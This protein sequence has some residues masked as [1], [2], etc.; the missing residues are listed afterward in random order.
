M[1][2]RRFPLPRLILLTLGILTA[3]NFPGAQTPTP[4]AAF[5]P[6]PA[7]DAP[8]GSH[9]NP[10]VL[11]LPPA[12]EREISESGREA[13]AQLSSLTG[14]VIIPYAP[15]SY[16][17]LVEALGEGRVH[18]AW[19]P[20]LPYLLAH[21]NGHADAALA[22]TVHEVDLYAA[23]FLVN[24]QQVEGGPFKVHFDPMTGRNLAQA[25]AA[26]AQFEGRKPCWTDSYSPYSYV[27]P[28][29]ILAENGI[30]TKPGAFMQGDEAVIRSL[31]RDPKGE[32]CQFGVTL[33]D[34]R[35][36][37]AAEYADV[38]EQ[39]VVVWVTDAIVPLNGFAYAPSLSSELRVS[40]SAAFLAILGNEAGAA[41]LRDAFPLTV[42]PG[43]CQFDGLKLVD[44]SF[45]DALRGV[46]AQSGLDLTDLVR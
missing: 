4:T 23:Q 36:A 30:E 3:C 34:S 6:T 7:R 5:T 15:A 40:L 16:T 13:A 26:L 11:A 25:A 38:S 28:L 18:I 2:R 33:V 10:I 46:Q 12:G 24:R 44:D 9:E 20:P 35:E 1:T 14:Q 31:Y 19:L 43:A 37:A 41:I 32:I 17:E 21:S 22:A 27:L 8:L 42:C 39:V 29:G 45:Y